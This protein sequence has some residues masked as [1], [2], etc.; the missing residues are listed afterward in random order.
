MM[1]AGSARVRDLWI[2]C[3]S[4]ILLACSATPSPAQ[5]L[6]KLPDLVDKV[7]PSVVSV[8]IEPPKGSKLG[9][10]SGSGIVLS[11]DGFI[12]TAANV[13]DGV[14]TAN[15]TLADG[16][17]LIGA[18]VGS[19]SR[20]NVAILKVHSSTP[21]Q[22]AHLANSDAVR[23][24]QPIFVIGDPFGFR[25]SVSIG[26]VSAKGRSI[27]DNNTYD[28]LQTD[29]AVNQGNSGGPLLDF[30]GNVIG[31]SQAIYSPTTGSVGIGFALPSN[32]IKEVAQ[33]IENTGSMTRGWLGVKLQD[34]TDEIAQSLNLKDTSGALIA[35]VVTGGP[36]AKAGLQSGD[37]IL[38]IGND[39]VTDS[40]S[41]ANAVASKAPRTSVEFT[42][43]RQNAFKTTKVELGSLPK[44]R[45]P[46]RRRC[47]SR[48]D[49]AR[50]ATRSFRQ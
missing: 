25:G 21:L 15:V 32:V 26:I 12:A 43:W 34:V 31:M 17:K 16:S 49:Q 2:G 9:P 30:D 36:G 35:D 13:V 41:A 4:T 10:Q 40:R 3:L 45:A 5:D 24:G 37:V 23:R 18:V 14:Q 50:V 8:A 7:A 44:T 47:L 28:Y 20:S 48:M 19:D 46:R 38:Q 11:S 39:K 42:L 27:G 22:E 29:A 33:Q 6:A 1:A